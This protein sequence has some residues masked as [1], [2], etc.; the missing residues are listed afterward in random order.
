MAF[1][2]SRLR[3]LFRRRRFETDMAEEIQSH[4]ERQAAANRAAGMDP[5]EARY[6]AMRRFGGVDQIKETARA[7]RAGVWLEQLAKDVLF[8]TRSLGRSRAFTATAVATLVLGIGVATASFN[9][10]AQLLLFPQPYPRPDRLWRIGCRE[11]RGVIHSWCLGVFFQA[12]QQQAHVFT[13][14]A[15]ARRDTVNVVVEGQPTT[16]NLVSISRGGFQTLGIVPVLG[17]AF[18]S[19]ESGAARSSVVV[20]SDRF[21]REHFDATPDILRRSLLVDG[22]ECAVVGVLKS[23]QPTPAGFSGD[24]YQPLALA[25]DPADPFR[26]ELQVIGRLNSGV[27]REQ[28]VADL[29][30]VHPTDV[31]PRALPFLAELTPLLVSLDDGARPDANWVVLAAGLLIY[32]I[33]CFNVL[34]LVLLRLMGR[35]RDMAIRLALGGARWRIARLVA[36]EAVGLS[37]AAAS[38][39]GL[40]ARWVFPSLFRWLYGGDTIE[41]YP[42]LDGRTLVCIG[43]L[44]AIAAG[45][46]LLATLAEVFRVDIKV[47][48]KTGGP[49]TRQD[50]HSGRLRGLLVVL[51]T[52]SAVL[53]LIGTGLLQRSFDKIRKLDLGFDAT[54][55]LKV[56]IAFPRAYRVSPEGRLQLFARLKERLAA[57]PGIKDVA[58][59][60][61]PVFAGAPSE[62]SQ[63][64][65][66]DGRFLPATIT[67][68]S[69]DLPQAAGLEFVKGRWFSGAGGA[70]ETVV[71]EGMAK[72]LF[73]ADDPIGR[74]FKLKSGTAF[75]VVGVIRDVRDMVRSPAGLRFYVPNWVYPPGISTLLLRLD[76]DPGPGLTDQIRRV[77]F[78]TDPR[79]V[80]AWVGSIDEIMARSL[81]AEHLVF[82]LLQVL[83]VIAL[84]LAVVGLF[85]L[86]AYAVEVRRKEFGVRLALGA[87]PSDLRSLVLGSGLA[88]SG[89]GIAVGIVA[90]LVGTQFLRSLLFGITPSDPSVFL[91]VSV[92]LA[93]VSAAACWLPARRAARVDATRL[94]R[95]E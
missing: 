83:S 68:A 35:R 72:L 46:I 64:Q 37:L 17:R 23:R 67:F 48:L 4:L 61:D 87:T 73:G 74:S 80:V 27:S 5:A 10:T 26:G 51:Q 81:W 47:D 44:A 13:G 25:A 76:R 11:T 39:V 36:T 3:Q 58:Y 38:V 2:L 45:A 20:I 43:V 1:P 60:Q 93:G 12:Y 71:T 28:A 95:A 92:M 94:L 49:V 54:G 85:S 88:L 52:A 6:A 56:Q 66:V 75:L 84:G 29:T 9:S 15:A 91:A 8:A 50:P 16:A 77:I 32:A 18:L 53:L 82:T 34:N 21:W 62:N 30:T 19:E 24:V 57:L 86:M 7:Q 79:L 14:F 40:I 33:A 41:Y 42:S 31:P 89:L 55:R 63:V 78:E 22:Q 70:I 90:A 69:E 59:G 65:T